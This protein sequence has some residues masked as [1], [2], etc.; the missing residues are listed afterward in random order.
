[1]PWEW[2]CWKKK[3]IH[4]KQWKAERRKKKNIFIK[5]NEKLSKTHLW[6]EE[7]SNWDG[8]ALCWDNNALLE[9]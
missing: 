4:K 7:T 9:F 1:M 6:G 5:S 3:H 8:E 2:D